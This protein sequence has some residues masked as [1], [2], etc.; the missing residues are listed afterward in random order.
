MEQRA[1][2]EQGEGVLSVGLLRVEALQLVMKDL[3]CLLSTFLSL[4]FL[5]KSNHSYSQAENRA[6]S[7]LFNNV[8]STVGL[9]IQIIFGSSF[10]TFSLL[11]FSCKHINI[12]L[13]K[14]P[15]KLPLFSGLLLSIAT[16]IVSLFCHYFSLSKNTV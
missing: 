15:P 11:I 3:Q 12:F 4:E 16:E 9:I 1:S 6:L 5:L 14:D 8:L 7:K 2:E 10:F 13:S